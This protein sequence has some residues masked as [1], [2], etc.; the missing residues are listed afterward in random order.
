MSGYENDEPDYSDH[1]EAVRIGRDGKN[2]VEVVIFYTPQRGLAMLRFSRL[3]YRLRSGCDRLLTHVHHF[4]ISRS[5]WLLSW[6]EGTYEI[7]QILPSIENSYPKREKNL[8]A[9][10]WRQWRWIFRTSVLDLTEENLL[11]TP[12]LTFVEFTITSP[13]YWL[14]QKDVDL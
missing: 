7:R 8:R 4:R 10:I 13:G 3:I 6:E 14:K 12:C 1:C 11:L 2:D 5:Q 9:P